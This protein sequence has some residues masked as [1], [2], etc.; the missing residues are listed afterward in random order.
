MKNRTCAVLVVTLASAGV[1]P[2]AG[3]VVYVENN[4]PA[5]Y[6]TIDASNLNLVLLPSS[7]A[8]ADPAHAGESII[9]TWTGRGTFQSAPYGTF[10]PYVMEVRDPESVS[11][12]RVVTRRSLDEVNGL[13]YD[14]PKGDGPIRMTVR[15]DAGEIIMEG[16]RQGRNASGE[17]R[18]RRDASYAEAASAT[19]GREAT[20]RDLFSLAVLNV[21]REN[22]DG[23]RKSGRSMEVGEIVRLRDR[24]VT[25]EY[26]AALNANGQ[27]F[28]IDEAAK[29]RTAGVPSEYVQGVR[30]ARPSA[31]VDEIVK[32]RNAGVS[33]GYLASMSGAEQPERSIEEV[34]RLRNSGVPAANLSQLQ[35]AGYDLSVDDAVRLRN[36]GVSAE[37]AKGVREAGYTPSVEA[38]IRLHNAGVSTQYLKEINTPGAELIDL[39]TAVEAKQKGLRGDFVR[40]LRQK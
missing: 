18:F 8:T 17:L 30:A 34:I 7:A 9:G 33:T 19:L 37:Y 28:S 40:K 6:S 36:A 21:S 26:L 2:L 22:L 12:S 38:L 24:G 25:G 1:L 11:N 5:S 10:M 15:R 23:Y 16:E 39:E 27:T 29:L 13:T 32:L 14:E 3:C 4:R 31:S 35:A 20:D